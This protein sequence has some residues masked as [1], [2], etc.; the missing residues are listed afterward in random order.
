MWPHRCT[1]DACGC[2]QEHELLEC[3]NTV[4]G[5]IKPGATC[6]PVLDT[7]ML[8]LGHKCRDIGL[9]MQLLAPDTKKH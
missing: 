4:C 9:V 2:V 8:W 3:A 6:G 1:P 5:K 7:D